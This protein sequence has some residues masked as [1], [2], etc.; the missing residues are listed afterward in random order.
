[1]LKDILPVQKALDA[2]VIQREVARY[3]KIAVDELRGERRVKHV[4]HARQV[5]M[6]LCRTLTQAS[7]P[8]IGK[9]FNKDHS[10]VLTSVR[11][12]EQLKNADDQLKLELGELGLKLGAV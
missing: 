9:K 5:A 11:K 4:S 6:Y 10:T 1:V 7:L 2:D 8:E 12:I 3:Y